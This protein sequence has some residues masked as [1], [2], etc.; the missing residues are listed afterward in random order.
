MAAAVLTTSAGPAVEPRAEPVVHLAVAR[1]AAIERTVLRHVAAPAAAPT[2]E[3]ADEDAEWLPCRD[4]MTAGRSRRRAGLAADR[5]LRFA[6]AAAVEAGVGR[7]Q[8]VQVRNDWAALSA[9]EYDRPAVLLRGY[10]ALTQELRRL[11][12]AEDDVY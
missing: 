9:E 2:P 10:T 4:G 12:A 1:P 3:T 6:Y 5:S 8:L 11:T 7:H